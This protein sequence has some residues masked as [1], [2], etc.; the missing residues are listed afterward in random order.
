MCPGYASLL[1]HTLIAG[2]SPVQG[3][4]ELPTQIRIGPN[5]EA[6]RRAIVAVV[7][8][9]TTTASSATPPAA[10]WRWALVV[11][12]LIVAL[13]AVGG[14]IYVLGGAPE[15]PREW[16]QGTP[17]DSYVVPGLTLLIA[18]GGSMTAAAVTLLSGNPR[19]PEMSI[20]AGIVLTGWITVQVLVIVPDGGFSWLQPTMFAVGVAV[21][22]IG[23]K[24][25]CAG[26]S[27]SGAGRR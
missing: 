23:W 14:S 9:M 25:R 6:G 2:V 16:L 5:R 12:E 21:A 18:V 8:V 24:L 10:A 19:A 17:F 11:T 7:T 1:C 13:S 15:W 27:G 20:V 4:G 22:S 3:C 26:V